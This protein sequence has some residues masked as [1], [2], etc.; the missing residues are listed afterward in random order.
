MGKKLVSQAEYARMCDP[1]LTRGRVSQLVKSGTIILVDGK[2]DPKQADSAR[3]A[4][5]QYPIT[6]AGSIS[7]RKKSASKNP[8]SESIDILDDEGLELVT[9]EIIKSKAKREKH[10]A[11]LAKVNA[12]KAEKKVV[13]VIE[14]TNFMTEVVINARDAMSAIPRRTAAV[15]SVMTDRHEIEQYLIKEIDS[16]LTSLGELLE[17]GGGES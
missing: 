6:G 12:D 4:S 11:R 17:F 14:V 10:M 16:A 7:S 2:V 3:A 15:V 13:D 8:K 9:D 5:S 1:P